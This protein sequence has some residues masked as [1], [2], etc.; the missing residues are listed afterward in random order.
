MK[1][2]RL[3]TLAILAASVLLTASL[4]LSQTADYKWP[5]MLAV[6]TDVMGG[7][8]HMAAVAL[9]TELEKGTGMKVRM[10]PE[11]SS[12]TKL[13]M[14][15]GG[16]VDLYYLSTSAAASLGVE[17]TGGYLTHTGGPFDIRIVWLG[18]LISAGYMVR[19]DSDIKSVADL[20]GKRVGV[21]LLTPAMKKAMEAL[22]AWGG[23]NWDDVKVVEFGSWPANMSSIAEG[24]ADV[25]YALPDAS[26]TFEAASG[27]HGV[28]FLE[29]D[30]EKEPEAAKRFLEVRPTVGF[31]KCTRG[32]KSAQGVVMPIVTVHLYALKDKDPELIYNLSK[33]LAENYDSYKDKNK[34]LATTSLQNFR[35]S[36]NGIYLPIHT[37]T[38]KF[39]KENRLWTE[40]DEKGQAYN[41]ELVGNYKKAYQQSLTE[42]DKKGVEINP[43]NKEW[44]NFWENYKKELGLPQFKILTK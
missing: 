33:W 22:L 30:P 42:A 14:L 2:T 21:C 26:H 5:R 25:V 24:K 7:N 34:T 40:A 12:T 6:A 37:G 18:R 39:L 1:K 8:A 13:K 4:G 15:R 20:K 23:L 41:V 35:T 31:G 32:V 17:V 44:V 10:V 29:M 38:I 9:G 19:G 28:R 36:L 43:K 27:P 11:G 3:F 16:I